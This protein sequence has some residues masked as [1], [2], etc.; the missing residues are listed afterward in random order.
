MRIQQP[1]L[2]TADGLVTIR[3]RVVLNKHRGLFPEDL[4]FSIP[5]DFSH[6]CVP[7]FEPFVV[8][9]SSLASAL[10]EDIEIDGPFS[11]RLSVGLNEYW[12]ILSTWEP[13]KFNPLRLKYQSLKSEIR[14]NGHAAAA[15]SGGVDLFFTQYLNRE[16]PAGFRTKYAVFI[17]GLDIPLSEANT[18]D[19]AASAY[20]TILR[21]N[22]VDL[23]RMASNVRSFFL[24]GFW[25]IGHGTA[26]CGAALVM[27]SGINRFFI[28]SSKSYGTLDPWGSHPLIDGLLSTD[29]TQIIHDGAYYTRFDKLKSDDGVGALSKAS[30]NL[31][32]E[33]CGISEL[34]AVPQVPT[35]NDGAGIAGCAR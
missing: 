18:F 34:R 21:E 27:S 12:R 2:E 7:S 30:A 19:D 5:E 22:S 15:F 6:L 26:L 32:Q 31:L 35:N 23:I 11:E 28:P 29:Q 17:H 4:W 10:N 13:K 8:A 16:R 25:E 20:E 9:L 33:A 3:A 24:P 1:Q 14:S